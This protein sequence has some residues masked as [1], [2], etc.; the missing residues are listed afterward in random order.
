MPETAEGQYDLCW[1]GIGWQKGCFHEPIIIKDHTYYAELIFLEPEQSEGGPVLGDVRFEGEGRCPL[2]EILQNTDLLPRV[3]LMR[4][5]V[6]I[7]ETRVNAIGEFVIPISPE[8]AED[9]ITIYADCP[10]LDNPD[11]IAQMQDLIASNNIQLV[12]T[13]ELTAT[14]KYVGAKVQPIDVNDRSLN[15]LTLKG[16]NLSDEPISFEQVGTQYY[17]QNPLNTVELQVSIPGSDP[18]ESGQ[19]V[20][21]QFTRD[22]V[23]EWTKAPLKAQ[24]S[25][26]ADQMV[27]EK[28]I[29]SG[30][31][32]MRDEVA[33]ERGKAFAYVNGTSLAMQ[34]DG[35]FFGRINPTTNNER[36]VLNIEADG[37]IPIS[38][39]YQSESSGGIFPME[40]AQSISFNANEDVKLTF[41]TPNTKQ[42]TPS[43]GTLTAQVEIDGR[44]LGK[45]IRILYQA[46]P[47]L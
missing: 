1:H 14:G 42:N 32:L 38:R 17:S 15:R 41:N 22:P 44:I 28:L 2:E 40:P 7:W 4:D 37:Y 30:R 19:N 5:G 12:G 39:I 35:L 10:D 20:I 47:S 43:I 9:S 27:D 26:E 11:I 36:Y 31:V 3:K 45:C 23:G 33:P 8:S 16:I 24:D 29:F 13:D 21:S 46:L 25:E 34:S 18:T 6:D